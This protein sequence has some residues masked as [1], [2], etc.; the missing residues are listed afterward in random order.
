MSLYC[1]FASLVHYGPRRRRRQQGSALIGAA[2]G[3][4]FQTLLHVFCTSRK[5]IKTIGTEVLEVGF[6]R[7]L[8]CAGRAAVGEL[9]TLIELWTAANVPPTPKP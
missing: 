4:A 8:S 5:F 1:A 7:G 9:L 6:G 3:S 2:T